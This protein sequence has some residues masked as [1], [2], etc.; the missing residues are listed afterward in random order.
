MYTGLLEGPGKV[1]D[2]KV[3]NKENP[4][5]IILS[6]YLSYACKNSWKY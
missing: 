2:F 3:L 1:L 4:V 6:L 5:Y